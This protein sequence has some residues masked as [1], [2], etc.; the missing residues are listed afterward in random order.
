MGFE[1]GVGGLGFGGWP[2]RY[3]ILLGLPLRV[4]QGVVDCFGCSS[5]VYGFGFKA[6]KPKSSQSLTL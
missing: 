2:L 4:I 1:Y 6:H 3:D 5:V